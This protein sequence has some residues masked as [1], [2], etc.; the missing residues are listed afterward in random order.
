MSAELILP[1]L[2][3]LVI[4]CAV[5]GLVASMRENP[6]DRALTYPIGSAER[7]SLESAP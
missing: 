1:L 5:A 3:S 7:E 4:V 6:R 2:A